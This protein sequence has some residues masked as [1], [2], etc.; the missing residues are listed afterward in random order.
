MKVPSLC[1]VVSMFE[2]FITEG[3]DVLTDVVGV[4]VFSGSLGDVKLP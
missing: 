4:G 2:Y 3:E 1:C